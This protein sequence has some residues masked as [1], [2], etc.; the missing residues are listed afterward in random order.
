MKEGKGNRW[1]LPEENKERTSLNVFVPVCVTTADSVIFWLEPKPK[2]CRLRFVQGAV[3]VDWMND[4][5]VDARMYNEAKLE[6]KSK[7]GKNP[8]M[9]CNT[10]NVS[11]PF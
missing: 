4:P 2:K 1:R 9:F 6:Y 3:R 10:K 11:Y 5:R 8:H 7:L